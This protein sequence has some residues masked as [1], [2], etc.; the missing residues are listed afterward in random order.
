MSP[1][2]DTLGKLISNMCVV[3]NEVVVVGV[4]R[5]RGGGHS[6]SFPL[7]RRVTSDPN[8]DSANKTSRKRFLKEF[9]PPRRS[10]EDFSKHALTTDSSQCE[11]LPGLTFVCA[12]SP[13]KYVM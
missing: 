3:L 12:A 1:D 8:I 11:F 4:G 2:W 9:Y 5:G 7:L 13:T 10:F 6:Y